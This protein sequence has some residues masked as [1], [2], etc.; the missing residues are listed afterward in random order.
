MDGVQSIRHDF[1]VLSS[2]VS[3]STAIIESP[4]SVVSTSL[5]VFMIR[6]E[7]HSRITIS[8]LLA[9]SKGKKLDSRIVT[10]ATEVR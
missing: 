4:P 9:L 1:V 6:L 2:P 5:K 10:G 8:A 7:K 3:L